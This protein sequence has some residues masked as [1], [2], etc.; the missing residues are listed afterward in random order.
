MGEQLSG[1][2]IQDLQ[3]LE[4]QLQMSMCGV[5]KQK[6]QLLTTEIQEL[7]RKGYLIHQENMELYKKMNL[8]RQENMELQKKVHG[9]RRQ[10]GTVNRGSI[11]PYGFSITDQESHV[12]VDL[13][14]CQPQ[15]QSN[16]DQARGPKL[17][18]LQ[19]H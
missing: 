1:L 5:R 13:E 17:G 10:N 11:T 19:L 16:G 7:N 8:M 2:S 18:R 15:H 12:P 14:L 3:N 4:N 6:E 9:S